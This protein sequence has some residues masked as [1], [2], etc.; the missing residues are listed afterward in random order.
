MRTVPEHLGKPT[1][2]WYNML[3]TTYGNPREDDRDR[4]GLLRG[5]CRRGWTHWNRPIEDN[6]ATTTQ[7]QI[8]GSTQ[9]REH[10]KGADGLDTRQVWRECPSAS[11]REGASQAN[12]LVEGFRPRGGHCVAPDR[13][14]S[15]DQA[16]SS[17]VGHRAFR[18][19][20]AD[21][22]PGQSCGRSSAFAAFGCRSQAQGRCLRETSHG[23]RRSSPATTKWD[24][25]QNG[26]SDSLILRETVGG[27]GNR[28][29]LPRS[30]VQCRVSNNHVNT[31]ARQRPGAPSRRRC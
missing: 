7:P 9:C 10:L 8:P 6:A 5:D 16:A 18:R 28:N 17:L 30:T 2:M 19:S 3:T 22:K 26:R 11:A 14:V 21:G 24:G 4:A 31:L 25:V 23:D 27:R 15:Q 12:L 29:R 13:A 1:G 20:I